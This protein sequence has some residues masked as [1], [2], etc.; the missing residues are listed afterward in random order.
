VLGLG[1]C[2]SPQGFAVWVGSGWSS[3]AEIPCQKKK[4]HEEVEAF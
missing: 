1:A 4:K 3:R 2:F